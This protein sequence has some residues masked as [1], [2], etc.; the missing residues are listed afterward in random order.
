MG[1]TPWGSQELDTNEVTE[2]AHIVYI[3]IERGG[4]KI[5]PLRKKNHINMPECRMILLT[6]LLAKKKNLP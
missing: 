6:K 4:S 3:Y 1:Y 5:F 2:Q